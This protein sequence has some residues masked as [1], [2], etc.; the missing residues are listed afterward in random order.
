MKRHLPYSTPEGYFQGLQ[1]RLADIPGK[2]QATTFQKFSPYL[3]LAAVFAVAVVVGNVIINKTSAP[4][5]SA[6][7]VVEYLLDSDLT[8]SQLEDAIFYSD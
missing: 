1:Q 2:K 7:E 8:L 6:M 3:A 4:A 5:A